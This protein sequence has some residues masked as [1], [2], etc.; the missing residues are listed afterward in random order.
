MALKSE[1]GLS[2]FV[3]VDGE[4]WLLD[5]GQTDKILYNANQAGIDFEQLN[6]II[7]SHGHYDH[8]GGVSHIVKSVDRA[9]VVYAHQLSAIAKYSVA[10]GGGM[11]KPNGWLAVGDVDVA[12]LGSGV[13]QL[14]DKVKVFTLPQ[15]APKN[16]RLMQQRCGVYEPDPFRDEIFTLITD[17]EGR[18][19]LYAGCT[20]HTLELLLPYLFEELGIEK[21]D[22]FIG[23]L[24]LMGRSEEQI[25]ESLEVSKRY[26]VGRWYVNHCTGD[27]AVKIW[28][29]EYGD[30]CM[31]AWTGDVIEL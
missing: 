20:H 15:D 29:A 28:Q 19:L 6:G 24:H 12:W 16:E 11:K 8:A 18:T 2:V 22:A 30:R 27:E 21:I 3:H 13:V 23:G 17:S 31:Q 14:S 4:K 7:V 5:A 1:H 10:T 26:N 9:P 25:R